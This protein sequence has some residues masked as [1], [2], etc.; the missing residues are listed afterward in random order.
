MTE[1]NG[2]SET[3]RKP[4]DTS[5]S[6]EAVI[7]RFGGL[8]PMAT[9]MGLAVSTVQGWKNRAHIPLSRHDEI[10]A[11]AEKHGIALDEDELT[12][13]CGEEQQP[14]AAAASEAGSESAGR[15]KGDEKTASATEAPRTTEDVWRTREPAAPRTDTADSTQ[16]QGATETPARRSAAPALVAGAVLLVIGAGAAVITRDAWLP[17]VDGQAASSTQQT[18]ER[19]Q[20]ID[21]RLEQLQNDRNGL[22]QDDLKPLASQLEGL[23]ERMAEL[24]GQVEQVSRTAGQEQDSLDSLNDQVGQLS[25]RLDEISGNLPGG[26][27]WQQQMGKLEDQLSQMTDAASQIRTRAES[28]TAA[29]FAVGQLRE[30]VLQARPYANELAAVRRL[31]GVGADIAEPLQQLED[32]AEQGVPSLAE[33]KRSFPATARAIVR[34]AR[35][36]RADSW[37]EEIWNRASALVTVRPVGER[38]GAD[39]EAIVARAER[40]LEEDRLPA[41]VQELETLQGP[42][43]EAASDWLAQAK[44]RLQAEQAL[45]SLGQSVYD[46]PA[47]PSGQEADGQDASGQQPDASDPDAQDGSDS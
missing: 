41:A 47:S 42:P 33:L 12:R 18:A 17:L 28:Q 32:G 14:Q 5:N 10:R 26:E 31:D 9:K 40:R 38:D 25:G 20:A 13:A 34:Q 37:A 23:D 15:A 35:E 46:S 11:A 30:A 21:G 29:A 6:A 4:E 24:A 22:T 8:R 36:E 45:K 2:E 43:A 7:A 1:D 39:A 19:L 16:A 44:R 27:V 3:P